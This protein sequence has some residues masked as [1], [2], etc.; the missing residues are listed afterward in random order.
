MLFSVLYGPSGQ[1]STQEITGAGTIASGESFG[2][3]VVDRPHIDPSGIAS[4]ETFGAAII[5]L[6]LDP[7]G[8][9]S[10]E[11][12]GT[13]TVGAQQTLNVVGIASLQAFGVPV[14]DRPHI[15]PVGIAS[16]ESFGVPEIDRVDEISGAGNIPSSGAFGTPVI[17]QPYLNPFSI[18]STEAFGLP[19]VDAGGFD[20]LIGVGAIESGE[21][22]GEAE[23]ALARLR[24][25]FRRRYVGRVY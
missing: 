16:Q 24:G 9:E 25:G 19:S 1:G 6:T 21:A 4:G 12:F 14:V 23:L 22:F 13:A 8:V 7:V 2:S 18:T 11:A 3:P 17:D 20:E 5:V 10:G 15:D